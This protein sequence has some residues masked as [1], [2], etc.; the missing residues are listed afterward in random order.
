MNKLMASKKLTSNNKKKLKYKM[1][2][3]QIQGNSHVAFI[4]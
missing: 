3:L 2:N 4:L 1:L